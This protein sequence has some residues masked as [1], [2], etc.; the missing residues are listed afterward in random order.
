MIEAEKKMKTK[1]W[2]GGKRMKRDTLF[3][4][5]RK[6]FH[7]RLFDFCARRIVYR[8]IYFFFFLFYW[9]V[10][11]FYVLG[12]ERKHKHL[13]A[14]IQCDGKRSQKWMS[15]VEINENGILCMKAN[16]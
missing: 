3:V 5:R 16:I 14:Y 2:N 4:W 9:Y 13:Q 8:I 6:I 11:L 1:E 10:D 12:H 15:F 7:S